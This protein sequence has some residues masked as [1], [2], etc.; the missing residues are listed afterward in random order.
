LPQNVH[1][2][3]GRGAKTQVLITQTVRAMIYLSVNIIR[4]GVMQQVEEHHLI[5]CGDFAGAF[6]V[7]V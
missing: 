4:F 6:A 2:E 7:G 1:G 3:P 5:I